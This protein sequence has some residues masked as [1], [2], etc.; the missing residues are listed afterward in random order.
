LE[1]P[2]N[3]IFILQNIVVLN[4]LTDTARRVPTM[5]RWGIEHI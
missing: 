1:I 3:R 5:C 2:P 4:R